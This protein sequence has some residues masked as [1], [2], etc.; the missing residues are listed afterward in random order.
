VRI[1][2]TTGASLSSTG[3]GSKREHDHSFSDVVVISTSPKGSSRNSPSVCVPQRSGRGSLQRRRPG[4]G[5]VMSKR[6]RLYKKMLSVLGRGGGG[7]TSVDVGMPSRTTSKRRSQLTESRPALDERINNSGK[8]DVY[9]GETQDVEKVVANLRTERPPPFNSEWI[10][11]HPFRNAKLLFKNAAD[12]EKQFLQD[13]RKKHAETCREKAVALLGGC[14]KELGDC[15][16]SDRQAASTYDSSG[17]KIPM[18]LYGTENPSKSFVALYFHGGGLKVGEADSEDISCRYLAV[19]GHCA[20]YSVSYRLMFQAPADCCVQDAIDAFGHVKKINPGKKVLL[21]GCSSGGMLAA[22][23]S[24]TVG[25]DDLLGVILRCPVT[26]D[27]EHMDPALVP[28]DRRDFMGYMRTGF[29]E[30]LQEQYNAIGAEIAKTDPTASARPC[31]TLKHVPGVL[32]RYDTP[33]DGLERMPGEAAPAH[34]GGLPRVWIQV[35]TNDP[36]VGD[37]VDY[38]RLLQRAGV[39]VKLDVWTGF[40][41]VFFHYAPELDF[42]MEAERVVVDKGLAWILS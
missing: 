42:S 33:R 15:P 10:P 39:E 5:A 14:W 2:T 34:V 18:K 31:P 32:N 3:H 37:G 30:K 35:C 9:H 21:I 23:V 41:H 16:V 12:E 40:P 8:M 22:L 26:I 19:H 4:T 27:A 17:Y 36:L 13:R 24:Q 11:L 20:V 7:R 38:A 1:E 6:K 28:S 29:A 25:K